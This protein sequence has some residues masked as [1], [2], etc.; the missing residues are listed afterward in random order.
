MWSGAAP[1]SAGCFRQFWGATAPTQQW[2]HNQITHACL[3]SVR[4]LLFVHTGHP[5]NFCL[6]PSG[7]GSKGAAGRLCNGTVSVANA[8]QLPA[9]EQL[10]CHSTHTTVSSVYFGL[11]SVRLTRADTLANPNE[12]QL[13][14]TCGWLHLCAS[15]MPAVGRRKTLPKS[16]QRHDPNR[17]RKTHHKRAAAQHC[18]AQL[19]G[20]TLI[21]LPPS[22]AHTAT[23]TR[24]SHGQPSKKQS[25]RKSLHQ[26]CKRKKYG[27]KVRGGFEVVRVDSI[28]GVR[29]HDGTAA[30][31]L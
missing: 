8:Q 1:S 16:A 20:G 28:S 29:A 4:A 14:V 12:A 27:R 11:W 25:T 13:P 3:K 5:L 23:A 31:R 10:P 15:R 21:F 7:R 9:A 19:T 26:G 6:V 2:Q 17:S 30:G 18:G 24:P 22:F